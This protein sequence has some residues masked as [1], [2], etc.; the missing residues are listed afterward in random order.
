IPVIFMFPGLGAEYVNMGL[1]LYRT[2]P[3]FRDELDHCFEILDAI[4]GD[5]IKAIL[6]PG[7]TGNGN[8]KPAP[9]LHQPGVVQPVLFIFEYALARLLMHWGI[10]PHAMIGYSFGEYTAACLAG[11]FS[12]ED[13]LKVIVA[14]GKLIG[15]L[16][17]GTMLSVPLPREVLK[18]YL[19]DELSIAI[20]NG[21]SC[22]VSGP[23]QALALFQN[24]LKKERCLSIPLPNSHAIHSPMMNP[25]LKDF[26]ISLKEIS[27]NKPQIPYISNVTGEWITVED[28]TNPG[29]WAT[30]LKE[31]VRFAEGIK[32]LM[33][34]SNPIFIEIGPGR[35]LS[36]LLVRHKEG[37]DNSMY[38]A[39]SLIKPAQDHTP[40]NYYFFNKLG[41]LWIYGVNIDWQE[42]YRDEQ[43]F[44]I[45]LPLYPFEGQRYWIDTAPFKAG[46]T[47]M[48]NSLPTKKKDTADW[49]YTQQWLRSTLIEKGYGSAACSSAQIR[50]LL[51]SDG[52]PLCNRLVKRLEDDK[53]HVVVVK[54]GESFCELNPGEY[55]VNPGTPGDYAD[56]FKTLAESGKAPHNIAHLWCLT[57][58][59]AQ[60][61]DPVLEL[62][63]FSL[64]DIARAIGKTNIT[65]KIQLGVI[66]GNMQFVTGE[67][68]LVPEK[69]AVLGPVKIIPLEYPNISCRSIDIPNPGENKGKIEFIS[70]NLLREFSLGFGDQPVVA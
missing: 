59:R 52:S 20:D 44:R 53:H 36:T 1:E 24:E 37:D 42:F 45:P 8:S 21:P 62:G 43:R 34:E 26:E 64:L 33:K 28:A 46:E 63:L 51:F 40:G 17:T 18:P 15:T 70:E 6:Y 14:R 66:T 57:G 19:T 5:D 29:Y 69:A 56:L 3:L 61:P 39:V 10:K 4:V 58:S 32:L 12:L 2:E 65:Q 35:D 55:T 30:H 7:E 25:I 11:V 54:A 68:E 38:R 50:W 9:G 41:Q 16:P 27:L 60:N 67:E 47:T 49:L 22:I 48:G 31:T 23:S 13:A